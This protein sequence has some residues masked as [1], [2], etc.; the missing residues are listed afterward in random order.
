MC[1]EHGGIVCL[2]ILV[3]TLR[4]VILASLLRACVALGPVGFST[5]RR[6]LTEFC[7]EAVGRPNEPLNITCMQDV[8]GQVLLSSLPQ[9]KRDLAIQLAASASA[10]ASVAS[11]ALFN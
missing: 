9:E 8:M 10:F 11:P 5:T 6:T 7:G 1:F 3:S 4:N 2:H